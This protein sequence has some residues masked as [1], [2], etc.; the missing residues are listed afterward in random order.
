M[1]RPTWPLDHSNTPVQSSDVRVVEDPAQIVASV[2]LAVGAAGG[3]FTVMVIEV[4]DGQA[5][6]VTPPQVAE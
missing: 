2:V 3:V 4:P 6:A 1:G 5:L